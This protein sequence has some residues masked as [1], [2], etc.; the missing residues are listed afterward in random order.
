MGETRVGEKSQSRM[1]T[2]LLQNAEWWEFLKEVYMKQG[3]TLQPQTLQLWLLVLRN[4]NQ[5]NLINDK[6][7]EMC[8]Y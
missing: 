4:E 3:D 1:G 6:M 2:C 5:L 7:R 8:L